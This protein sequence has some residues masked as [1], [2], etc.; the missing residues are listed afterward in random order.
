MAVSQTKKIN[1]LPHRSL[2][3]KMGQAGYSVSQAISELVDNSIDA[4]SREPLTVEVNLDRK[5]CAIQVSDNGL[6]M[7]EKSAAN[8][9]K[10]AYSSKKDQLGEYGLGLKTAATSLGKKF[11]VVTTQKNSDKEYSLQYDEDQWIESG[12]WNEHDMEIKS[13]IDKERSGT[14]VYIEDLRCKIYANLPSNL[15]KDLA[16]RFAPFIENDELELKVNGKQ[17][18][19]EPLELKTEYYPENGGK[20]DFKFPLES[21]N[22]VHGWRGLLKKGSGR[23]EYGF[24]VFR[25]GRLVMQFAKLGFK[26][27]PEAQQIVGEIHLDHIPVTHNKREFI[28]ESP[29][30]KEIEE[31]GGIFWNFMTE[32]VRAARSSARKSVISQ[33]ILDKVESQKE[34]IMKAIKQ[35]PDIHEYAFPDLREKVRSEYGKDMADLEVEDRSKREVVTIKHEPE[36]NRENGLIRKPRKVHKRKRYYVTVNGKNFEV[37][38]EFRDLKNDDILKDFV[39]DEETGIKV[40]TNSSF[41]GFANSSDH[42]FYAVWNIAEAIAEIMVEQNDRSYSEVMVLRDKILKRASEITRDIAEIE[43]EKKNA[44]RFKKGYEEAEARIMEIEKRNTSDA[45]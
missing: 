14:I 13:G 29:L 34:N 15:R 30:Y 40:I 2:M 21:E 1:I 12:S 3:P 41:P 17:C 5:K 9:I 36:S 8:S 6:G 22:V 25:R 31:E 45:F 16:T 19:P 32:I 44:E 39:I 4:R 23:G 11:R 10:L 42:V 27:H 37:F 33:G 38:H 18:V 28:Q 7:D 24:R 26:P 35:I 20:E 43:R